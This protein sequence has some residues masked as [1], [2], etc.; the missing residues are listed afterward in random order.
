MTDE[1]II[2]MIKRHE[3][4]R[5]YVYL[6]S[7][8]IP[9]GGYGHAFLAG[10]SIPQDV[11]DRLL[12]EDMQTA[13]EDYDR[14]TFDLDPVRRGVVI[15]MLFNLGFTKF[16]GFFNMR[17]A[18]RRGDYGSAADEMLDSQWARQVGRRAEELARIMRT[19]RVDDGETS[20]A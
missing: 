16:R 12:E 10:S 20:T 2:A 4:F 13:F 1:E 17:Q 15:N 11:A 3:G 18:L 7:E 5:D 8:G 14:L 9:T 6:D 19:G